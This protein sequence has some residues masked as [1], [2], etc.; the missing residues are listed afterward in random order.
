MANPKPEN[1]AVTPKADAPK[2]DSS[3][4]VETKTDDSPKADATLMEPPQSDAVKICDADWPPYFFAGKADKP[5]GLA[6]EVLEQCFKNMGTKH[7]FDFYPIGRMFKYME[8][9]KIDI[10]VF[11]MEKDRNSF[12]IYG[13]EPLFT[14]SYRAFTLKDSAIQI[15]SLQDFEPLK[16][17]HLVGL[18]YSKEFTAYVEKREKEGRLVTVT[19]PEAGLRMLLAKRI[20]VFVETQSSMLWLAKEQGVLDRIRTTELDI[21]TAPFYVTQSKKS[22]RVKEK[23]Q[24]IDGLDACI[25]S[26][27]ADGSY[28]KITEKYGF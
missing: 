4:T 24:F 26:M 14:E 16:L 1:K 7:R 9:G 8:D 18:R 21:K 22:P 19:E 2:A 12:L 10:N 11:S 28:K 17:G 25:K 5:K 20:D 15:K 27:K 6:K 13:K 23:Q 3:K